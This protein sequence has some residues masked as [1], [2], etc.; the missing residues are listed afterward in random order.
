MLIP[1][2]P[3]VKIT[4]TSSRPPR[5][6]PHGLMPR[7]TWWTT[8]AAIRPNTAPDAPTVRACGSCIITPNDPASSEAMYSPAY[9]TGPTASS[10]WRPSIHSRNM[11]TSRCSRP[12]WRKP[13]VSRRAHSPSATP[14][15][16]NPDLPMPNRPWSTVTVPPPEAKRS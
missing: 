12:A 11:L 2:R 5:P 1:G 7:R 10:I 3:N 8:A 6:V 13:P 4:L 15:R 16:E 9:R 14:I